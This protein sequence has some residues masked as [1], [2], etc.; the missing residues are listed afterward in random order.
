MRA[1]LPHPAPPG[2]AR[3]VPRGARAGPI[4]PTN[5]HLS[6][7]VKETAL[8]HDT[9]IAGCRSWSGRSGPAASIQRVNTVTRKEESGGSGAGRWLRQL[10]SAKCVSKVRGSRVSLRSARALGSRHAA[11]LARLC[12]EEPPGGAR[13]EATR[14]PRTRRRPH[15]AQRCGMAAAARR[16]RR[17]RARPRHRPTRAR[18]APCAARGARRPHPPASATRSTRGAPE[19]RSAGGRPPEARGGELQLLSARPGTRWRGAV[20]RGLRP[21]SPTFGSRSRNPE[22]RGLARVGGPST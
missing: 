17:R 4:Q 1:R 3:A 14:C 11:C 8:S 15:A 21:A 9:G 19:R 7:N 5:A 18:A 22:P 12:G 20:W 16:S 2:G 13:G 6:L 10:E